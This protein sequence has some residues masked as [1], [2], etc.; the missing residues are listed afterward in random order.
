MVIMMSAVETFF[1]KTGTV[2]PTDQEV[3]VIDKAAFIL[4]SLK[5]GATGAGQREG[6]ERWTGARAVAFTERRVGQGEQVWTG[7]SQPLQQSP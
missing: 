5:R 4:M 2:R 7:V 3:V 6:W 1:Q